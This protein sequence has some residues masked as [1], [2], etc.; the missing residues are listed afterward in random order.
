M[1]D[2]RTPATRHQQILID[3]A[4][5]HNWR[6]GAEIG[7][8]KGKTLR[9]LLE[10]VDG[11]HMVAVDMWQRQPASIED[12]AETYDRYDLAECERRVEAIATSHPGRVRIIKADSVHAARMVDDASL[13]FVFIDAA[14]TT[15]ATVANIR[16]WTPKVRAGG[17]IVGHDWWWASVRNALNLTVPGWTGMVESVW[18]ID[19]DKVA[20]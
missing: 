7:V 12:G 18:V 14:H 13:D 20:L 1:T 4:E 5:R 11:L 9:A 10:A 3:L 16:A 19:R 17:Q 8:L 2:P 6:C 15:A